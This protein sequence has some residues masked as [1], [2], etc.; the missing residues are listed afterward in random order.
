M[1]SNGCGF[2]RLRGIN[3]VCDLAVGHAGPHQAVDGTLH[4]DLS[5]DEFLA[6]GDA[7]R[8][9]MAILQAN[10]EEMRAAENAANKAT[11][12]I[13]K[14]FKAEWPRHVEQLASALEGAA[15]K[16]RHA[17]LAVERGRREAARA[18]AEARKR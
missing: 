6:L 2:Y 3:F 10:H 1:V 9:K 7:H 4:A 12:A 16:L 18:L 8:E 14:R 13:V 5:T 15:Q 11:E 17:A